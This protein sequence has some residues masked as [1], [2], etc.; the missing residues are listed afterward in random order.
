MIKLST[1]MNGTVSSTPS[2]EFMDLLK[3]MTDDNAAEVSEKIKALREAKE[4]NAK[5]DAN[6][7]NQQ[8]QPVQPVVAVQPQSNQLQIV[9]PMNTNIQQ[10]KNEMYVNNKA[11]SQ[12]SVI[13]NNQQQVVQPVAIVAIVQSNDKSKNI[14]D[15]AEQDYKEID[16]KQDVKKIEA[17]NTAHPIDVSLNKQQ[18]IQ[19]ANPVKQSKNNITKQNVKQY[20]NKNQQQHK[21]ERYIN[22]KAANREPVKMIAPQQQPNNGV[23]FNIH[24]FMLTPEQVAKKKA[25]AANAIHA[26]DVILNNQQQQPV[27]PVVAVQPQT[28]QLQ[29]VQPMNPENQ[30]QQRQ[31][32]SKDQRHI[33]DKLSFLKTKYKFISGNHPN[34]THANLD[35]LINL[36][37]ST[38]LKDFCKKYNALDNT[39]LTEMYL[40]QN[41]T[42]EFDFAFK[43]LTTDPKHPLKVLFNSNPIFDERTGRWVNKESVQVLHNEHRDSKRNNK[44]KKSK[45]S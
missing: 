1:L 45:R 27:Q 29:I 23:G 43:I 31:Y 18:Q 33:N 6:L 5:Q 32:V 44:N 16:V 28:N 22:N 9:Q 26:T 20:V 37:N 8:Q 42:D 12:T 10:H 3:T 38:Y 17:V 7:N 19:P 41:E 40:E 35:S 30:Q 36:L 34:L 14:V 25:E 11:A 2:K 39:T 24:N 13:P 15:V 4:N 21:N